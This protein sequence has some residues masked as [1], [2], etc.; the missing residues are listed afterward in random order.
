MAAMIRTY[1][2][3]DIML[4]STKL[5]TDQWQVRLSVSWLIDHG[6]TGHMSFKLPLQFDT[7]DDALWHGFLWAKCWIDDGRP[8]LESIIY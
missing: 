5:G 6:N 3:H 1:N 4:S 2:G 7:D 8:A